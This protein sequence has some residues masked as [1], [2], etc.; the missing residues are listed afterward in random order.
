MTAAKVT[1]SSPAFAG[2][3]YG[4]IKSPVVTPLAPIVKS[5]VISV[6]EPTVGAPTVTPEPAPVHDPP[7]PVKQSLRLVDGVPVVVAVKQ[8]SVTW[9]DNLKKYWHLA[10]VI[11]GMVLL[12]ISEF[13]PLITDPTMKSYVAVVISVLTAAGVFLKNNEHWVDSE[14]TPQALQLA[15][16]GNGNDHARHQR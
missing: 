1:S 12:A 5:P 6:S 2:F 16:K 15:L 8:G 13:S 3:L 4:L 9:R 7:V 10:I 11:I 14:L